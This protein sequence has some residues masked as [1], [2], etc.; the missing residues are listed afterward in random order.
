[1]AINVTFQQP[2]S[3]NVDVDRVDGKLIT[4]SPVTLKNS[5]TNV[6]RDIAQINNVT[7]VDKVNGSTLIWNSTTNRYEVKLLNIDDFGDPS[8]IDGGTF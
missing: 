7:E 5:I 6:I 8:D 4:A 1:M 2:G 3:I